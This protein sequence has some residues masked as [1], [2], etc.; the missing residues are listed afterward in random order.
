[1]DIHEN[2]SSVAPFRIT[3]VQGF[4]GPGSLPLD[5]PYANYQGGN[6]YPFNYNPQNPTFP[7]LPYQGFLPI[8]PNLKTSAQ[9]SWNFG[10]QHQL[11]SNLFVSATY[12]GTEIAHVWTGVDLNPAIWLPGKPVIASPSS[13]AQFGQCAAL[14]ANCGGS[15]E[16]FRRLLEV[17]NPTAPNV[18]DYGSITSLDSGGTQHY[19]GLLAN[20]RWRA[21]DN[22]NISTNWTWS[23]CIGL[24]PPISPISARS[25]R[26]S[27]I[28]T[29]DR[30]TAIWIWAIVMAIQ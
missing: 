14:Q 5:N 8:D 19:N 22:L 20:A 2:T 30:R 18:N 6:P 15:A 4:S 17:T 28:R 9:Y 12:V 24:P 25:T 29:T 7:N 21:N 16:N 26:I 10:I 11:T 23:H 1:M 27:R 3:V 13:A